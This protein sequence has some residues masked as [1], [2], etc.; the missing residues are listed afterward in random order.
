MSHSN[1]AT[2]T[3]PREEACRVKLSEI[4]A[5]LPAGVVS[6]GPITMG[7][8][9][10]GYTSEEIRYAIN[11]QPCGLVRREDGGRGICTRP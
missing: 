4:L 11:H 7:L 2:R 8:F 9:E 10:E 5:A 1:T 6:L 3:S